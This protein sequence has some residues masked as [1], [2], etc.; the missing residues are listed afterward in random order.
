MLPALTAQHLPV[1]PVVVDTILTVML[2]VLVLPTAQFVL[3]LRLV[4]PA[5]QEATTQVVPVLHVQV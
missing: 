5:Q 3:I 4:V 2:A 1:I